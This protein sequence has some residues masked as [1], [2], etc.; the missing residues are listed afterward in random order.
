M[1]SIAP[2]ALAAPADARAE[3]PALSQYRVL[4]RTTEPL[5]VSDRP[6]EDFCIAY[7]N[8]IREGK[9]WRMWYTAYDHTYQD[10]RDACLCYA[11]SHDGVHWEKPNLGMHDYD[12]N[13][14]NNILMTGKKVGGLHGQYV[15][16]D[17]QAPATERYKMV[18]STLRDGKWIVFGAHSIEGIAWFFRKEPLLKFNSDTQTVCLP[19]EKLYRL[20][21][22]MW[23]GDD[24]K[25]LR[26]VGYS[27]SK[28]FGNFTPPVQILAPDAN[29]PANTDF[30]NNAVTRVA[31]GRYL[32]FPSA[33]HHGKI[34][35][36]KDVVLPH[37]ATSRDGR[38]FTRVGR[39]PLVQLGKGFDSKGIYVLPGAVPGDRPGTWW[40]YYLGTNVGHD[41]HM[42]KNVRNSGGIGRFL[43][44][45]E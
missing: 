36:G 34:E 2:F 41:Q 37:L 14:D 6:H 13:R 16:V 28:T 29:D 23:T 5:L 3:K 32:M 9:L 18:Y 20:Y 17:P 27:E 8:V 35:D 38:N 33:F 4:E 10:D 11:F 26:S 19:D 21:V 25:G 42:P 7:G 43:L 22:R 1:A 31:A 39:E 30:Y 15:F 40:F 45:V 44:S 12:G 24:Y